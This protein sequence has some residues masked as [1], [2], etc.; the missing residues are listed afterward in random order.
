MYLWLLSAHIHAKEDGSAHTVYF[1]GTKYITQLR[2]TESTLCFGAL[3]RRILHVLSGVLGNLFHPYSR[4]PPIMDVW[5][6]EAHRSLF[7][8]G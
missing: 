3:Y 2:F 4:T 7:Q 8:V 1:C 5:A 6:T